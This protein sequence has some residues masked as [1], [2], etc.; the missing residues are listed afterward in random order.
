MAALGAG[1]SVAVA[2]VGASAAVVEGV[3]V[4]SVVGAELPVVGQLEAGLAARE[5]VAVAGCNHLVRA[6]REEC[7]GVPGAG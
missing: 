7:P 1:A 4:A 5:L 3:A 2:L 6:G